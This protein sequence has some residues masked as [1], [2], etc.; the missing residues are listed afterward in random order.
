MHGVVGVPC[1]P[2]LMPCRTALVRLTTLRTPRPLPTPPNPLPLPSTPAVYTHGEMI[3]A[4]GYPKLKKYPHLA[5]NYG[6]AWYKQKKEFSDLP[7][8]ILMT[9]NCVL[10][11]T[12]YADNL[13][14]T[15][16]MMAV[17]GVRHVVAS[18]GKKDFSAVIKRAM[19]LPGFDEDA[20]D[21]TVLVG[22]GHATVLSVADKASGVGV[23]GTGM[24][25]AG[26]R[27]MCFE[28]PTQATFS[29][30]PTPPCPHPTQVLEAVSQGNLRHIFL[31]G[32][33]D[34]RQPE[35]KYYAE[36]V[37]ALPQDT[38]VLTLGCAKYRF[39]D[40][41]LGTLPNTPIPRLLDMGQCNDA[42]SAIAVAS[43]LADALGTDINS[44]PLSL[45]ISWF[46]QKAVSI[47]LTLL[48]LGVRNIR[49][50]P[51]LPAFLT[52][53]AVQL[54]VDNWGLKT[55]N[56]KDPEADIRDMMGAAA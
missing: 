34:G 9:T 48:H 8:A 13:F 6:G 53:D 24:R 56:L 22:F 16:N 51:K 4:H 38:L 28:K 54:I 36:L 21:R 39:F 25:V 3:P 1:S 2:S 18:N 26:Q 45:D 23:V 10:I 52:P 35:R 29:C 11:P 43:A 40:H 49:L 20:E 32:G 19:E 47:L 5:G 50:G 37:D 14:T 33:C 15:G 7:G 30:E 27:C 46:E 42:Y 12:D 44:L 17:P 41:D 55:P 31:V